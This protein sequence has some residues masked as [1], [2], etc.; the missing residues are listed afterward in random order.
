[1]NDEM[2]TS[3]TEAERQE[4]ATRAAATSLVI[5]EV[6]SDTDGVDTAEF[7]ELFDGG[8]GNTALDGHALVFFNGNGDASY[9]SIDLS[10][11]A[12]GADGTFVVGNEGVAGVDVV[13]P[14]NGLQNGADAVALYA[15]PAADFPVGTAPSTDGLVDALVYGTGDAT[16]AALLAALGQD[17]QYDE[18]ANGQKDTQSLARTPDGTGDF[19][20]RAP[21]PGAANGVPAPEPEPEPV[22]T[23]DVL[24]SDIQGSPE[25]QGEDD[26]GNAGASPLLDQ[27]VRVEG[28]VTASFPAL[29]GFFLQEEAADSDGDAASSEGI[30]V[31]APGM[32]VSEGYTV[33]VTGVVGEYFAKTQIGDVSAIDIVDAGD[34][35]GLIDVP[36]L[37]R[38]DFG[39]NDD[40]AALERFESMKVAFDQPMVVSEYFQLSRFGEIT[41]YEGERP[42]QFTQANEPDVEGNAAYLADLASRRIILDDDDNQQNSALPDGTVYHP[43]PDG[44]SVDDTIRGGDTVAELTGVLDWSFAGAGAGGTDAWRLRPTEADPVAFERTNPRTDAPED[45]GNSLKVASFNV[46]NY[47]TTIDDGEARTATGLEPRGAD[48]VAELE[49]QTD[50]IVSALAE[51]DAQ[52]YGLIEVENDDGAATQA[53]VDALNVRTDGGTY[54]AIDTGVIGTDAIKVA[55]I[56]DTAQVRPT[57]EFAILDQSVDPRFLDGA[58][59]PALAQTFEE[60]SSGGTFT[61]AVNHLK[62]KGSVADGDAANGDGSGN[63]DRVRTDAAEAL[64][65]WLATD[66]TGSGDADT[67]I[68]GD[69]NSYAR[70]D[71]I[72]AIRDGADGI[73]GTGDDYVDLLQR[74][75]GEE[76]YTYLFD[77][78]LGTLDYALANTALAGQVTGATAWHINA[79]EVPLLDYNDDVQDPSEAPFEEEPSGNDLFAADAFRASDHDPVVVGLDLDPAFTPLAGATDGN[80]RLTGTDG[81]DL[82]ASGAG[83]VDRV[84]GGEGADRFAFGSETANGTRE[85]DFITDYEVGLDE[86]DLG[87]AD[88]AAIREAGRHV[89]ITLDGDGDDIVVRFVDEA[90]DLTLLNVGNP[91]DF[92]IA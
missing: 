68:L 55:M 35:L 72:D 56:Y 86:I 76:A 5:N 60:I 37:T 54:A 43:R 23:R 84:A 51:I 6:D 26:F 44:L 61:A 9:R 67:L 77:G 41:L 25:T 89:R 81:R 24:I 62:S 58:N 28:V 42:Y 14:S 50:K 90:D 71:P 17:V 47:F 80:D 73:S 64:V 4:A 2:Q 53:L 15:R 16:D 34:N 36:A 92:A 10:G 82:I 7:V 87:G 57:G 75:Q 74:D 59:R 49:R 45:V 65:D 83:R 29:D 63:N 8:A 1:M 32:D 39:A 12:T 31:Y 69:L 19:A 18:D 85:R 21:T 78:Q 88:I 79:D 13:I 11:Y 30:F 52:V 46:L 48:S 3:A 91:A 33:S 40:P 66:P 27:G 22:E 20:A 38:S 70:E